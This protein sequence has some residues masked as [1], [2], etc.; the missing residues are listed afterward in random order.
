MASEIQNT[1][2]A[3][4]PGMASRIASPGA[5]PQTKANVVETPAQPKVTAPRPIDIKFDAA[6][7]RQTL[8]EAV[9]FLNKQ[10]N[11]HNRGIGFSIDD[12][13]ETP[14]VT[15]RSTITGEVVRQIPNEAAVRM[16]HNI[17]SIK[18]M[19]INANV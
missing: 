19:L 2:A 5:G 17:E 11:E 1:I 16:A 8:Q 18:G 10:L 12:S 4:S 14:V 13:L 7:V 3:G 15:V 9:S 6:E